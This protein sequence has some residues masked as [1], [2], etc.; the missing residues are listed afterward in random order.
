[1]SDE[2]RQFT[3]RRNTLQG[4]A[5]IL[6]SRI[7]QYQTQIEGIDLERKSMVEQIGYLTDEISGLSELYKQDLVP[8]SRLLAL[9]RDRAQMQG[10]EG[11]ALA[12][13]SQTLKAIGEAQL[14]ARQLR[15]QFDQDVSKELSDVQTQ[16]GDI[17]QKYTVAQDTAR[18]VDVVAP[19]SGT[20]QNVRFST[21]GAVVRPGEPLVDIA[22]DRGALVI[23]AEF[24]PNDVDSVHPGQMV[25]IRFT[26]FHARN[27][28]VIQGKVHSV[29]QD[30]LTDEVTHQ[31]YYLAIV[32]LQDAQIPAEL[33]SK[34]RAGFPAEIIVPTGSRTA[35]QYL[36]QPL[37]NAMQKTMREQ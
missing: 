37:T 1:M 33:R 2:V 15:Q 36:L 31:P 34:I 22:P 13:R 3:E 20:V 29:S 25:Q 5:D 4:Q 32:R 10:Q 14:Q 7:A 17:R 16:V 12:E 9:E 28:P 24:S 35:L 23:R 21:E 27:I 30:R 19:M 26:T 6:Q 11:H 8:K 18:R